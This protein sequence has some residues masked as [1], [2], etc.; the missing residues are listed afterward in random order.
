[1]IEALMIHIG[2]IERDHPEAHQNSF[3]PHPKPKM[4]RTGA[5]GY[6][7]HDDGS[8]ISDYLPCHYF[9]L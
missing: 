4:N 7:K 2:Q 8:Y 1:M 5:T 9:G 6:D 3:A